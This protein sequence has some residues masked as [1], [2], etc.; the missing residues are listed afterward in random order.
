MAYQL[1]DVDLTQDVAGRK[2]TIANIVMSNAGS[3]DQG[4]GVAVLLRDG[5]RPIALYFAEPDAISLADETLAGEIAHRLVGERIRRN[6]LTRRPGALGPQSR[7][8]RAVPGGV[9]VVVCTR[10]RPDDLALCLD[11]ILSA[12]GIDGVDVLVVDNAPPDD[13]TRDVV[14]ARQAVRYVREPVPGLNVARNRALGLALGAWIVFVD[15][16]V[17]VDRWWLDGLAAA[18]EEH[19]DAAAVTGLVLPAELRTDAQVRFERSGGFGRGYAQARWDGR[20]GPGTRLHPLGAGVF[21]VG[22]N[23]AFQVGRMRQLGGFDEGLDTG[24]PLAGGGDL[25]AFFRVLDAGHVLVYEPRMAVF[26]RHRR[27]MDELRSQYHSWGLGFAAFLDA[28]RRDPRNRSMAVRMTVW[29]LVY[30]CGRVVDAGRRRDRE[31]ARMALAELC[32]GLTGATGEYERSL[33]RIERRRMLVATS[34]E[35]PGSST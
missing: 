17:R 32:G 1:V 28:H 33:R 5:C 11:S 12:E 10:N 27:E 19:P 24:P 9:T 20:H 25:D 8:P 29:W 16:D 15:D 13:L 22:C 14:A 26:H 2:T 30:A 3:A 23:M 18:L 4:D 34:E 7:G 35:P 31:G 6:L 21:G